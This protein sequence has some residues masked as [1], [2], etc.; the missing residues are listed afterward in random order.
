M[1]ELFAVFG[2]AIFSWNGVFHAQLARLS[3]DGKVSIAIGGIM[4]WIYGGVLAGRYI[5]VFGALALVAF[6]G[7]AC[8]L[9][10]RGIDRN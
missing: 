9:P 10:A 2:A 6:A 3:P 1:G 8:T 5:T 7:W 4:L